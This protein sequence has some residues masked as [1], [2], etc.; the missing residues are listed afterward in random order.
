MLDRTLLDNFEP[1]GH[2]VDLSLLA[3]D[4]EQGLAAAVPAHHEYNQF[5]AQSDQ[6]VWEEKLWFLCVFTDV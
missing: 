4:A 2:L 6:E 5:H 1:A 3:E